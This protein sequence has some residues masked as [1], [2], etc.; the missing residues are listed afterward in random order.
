MNTIV[1]VLE[2]IKDR[3]ESFS[4]TSNSVSVGNVG[5]LSDDEFK[6]VN[7]SKIFITV[8]K[9]DEERL[10]N[11][12]NV[13]FIKDG[14]DDY[15]KRSNPQKSFS[16]NLLFA[17]CS[18]NA[19]YTDSL[20]RL[21]KVL[22][23]FQEQHIY[24]IPLPGRP[25]NLQIVLEIQNMDLNQQNQLWSIIGGKYLPSVIYKVK[26]I[27][28]QGIAEDGYGII[29]R[30]RIDLLDKSTADGFVIE[31]TNDLTKN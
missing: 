19:R 11:N 13:Y 14:N 5:L 8:L 15:S 1:P 21:E 6:S 25:E 10:A 9:I 17:A 24:E 4:G 26:L 28:I 29:E 22:E 2:F 23:C 27:P 18:S 3:I 12:K 31:T 7:F 16:L 20:Q 30:V